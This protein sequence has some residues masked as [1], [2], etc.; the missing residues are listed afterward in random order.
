M[1]TKE[2][3]QLLRFRIGET[4]RYEQAAGNACLHFEETSRSDTPVSGHNEHPPKYVID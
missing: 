2:I 4:H 1:R 3:F